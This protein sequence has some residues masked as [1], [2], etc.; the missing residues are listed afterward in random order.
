[1]QSSRTASRSVRVAAVTAAATA[2]VCAGSAVW[3]KPPPSAGLQ[4]V[5]VRPAVSAPD[6]R[7]PVRAGAAIRRFAEPGHWPRVVGVEIGASEREQRAGDGPGLDVRGRWLPV[8]GAPAP[9]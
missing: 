3:A 9:D 7:A 6:E 5:W 4:V 2:V 1:M 8:P